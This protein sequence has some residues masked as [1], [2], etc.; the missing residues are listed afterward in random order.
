MLFWFT[1]EMKIIKLK[2]NELLGKPSI[3]IF[4]ESRNIND[5]GVVNSRRRLSWRRSSWR[6]GGCSYGQNLLNLHV[7]IQ[8]FILPGGVLL[9]DVSG[10]RVT[11]EVG[12]ELPHGPDGE[13]PRPFCEYDV[14]DAVLVNK[15][16]S[17]DPSSPEFCAHLKNAMV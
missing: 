16:T 4:I 14:G 3:Y 12:L 13:G 7:I 8:V 6:R 5:P 1:N 11:L 9:D 2:F 15:L 10:V 17:N